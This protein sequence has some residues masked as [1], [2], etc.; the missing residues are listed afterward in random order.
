MP[1]WN[2]NETG[3]DTWKVTLVV[4]STK[5][6]SLKWIWTAD[7]HLE[8]EGTES[9]IVVSA[10][11]HEEVGMPEGDGIRIHTRESLSSD[12]MNGFVTEKANLDSNLQLWEEKCRKES[13]SLDQSV[14]W[15]R[16]ERER[17]QSDALLQQQNRA[18][19]RDHLNN[20]SKDS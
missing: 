1:N 8:T 15:A 18:Q 5:I 12:P 19:A 14:M 6:E 9:R 10:A 3:E 2:I 17:E 4:D 20:L 11:R 13:A 16:S 7:I